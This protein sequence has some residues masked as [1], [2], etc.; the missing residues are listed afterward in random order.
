M[1]TQN[2]IIS[3]YTE[4]TPNPETMKFVANV[5]IFARD[6]IDMPSREE[7]EKFS[8][9]ATALF[10]NFPTVKGVFIANN[11]VTVTKTPDAQWFEII[12]AKREFIRNY[13]QEE[14]P[15]LNEE[16]VKAHKESIMNAPTDN[17]DDDAIVAKIKELLQKYV[18]PAVEMDGGS[19]VFRS[20][21]EGK[22]TLAMEGSCAG[23][24]SS[25]ITL[26]HSIE[27]L[28]RRM[29]PEVEEVVAEDVI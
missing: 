1:E 18:Q 29:V 4:A 7:A 13:L 24:P 6:R 15:V 20:F 28:L 27:N 8:P 5:M 10:D 25:T 21:E 17:G 2:R 9:L 16:A 12:P 14:H 26:K 19:I 3:L 23:C 22:V 11:F